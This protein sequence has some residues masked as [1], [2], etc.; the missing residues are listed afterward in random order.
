MR[1]DR[2]VH[3]TKISSFWTFFIC[4]FLFFSLLSLQFQMNPSPL[5]A[6]SSSFLRW[7]DVVVPARWNINIQFTILCLWCFH[8]HFIIAFFP[9]LPGSWSQ[10]AAVCCKI[11]RPGGSRCSDYRELQKWDWASESPAAIQ[12]SNNQATRL[13]W[14]PFDN[15]WN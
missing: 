3:F 6:S 14:N 4:A 13:V 2:N 12:R 15:T 7:L 9:G 11:C 1:E 8:L 10:E 5:R